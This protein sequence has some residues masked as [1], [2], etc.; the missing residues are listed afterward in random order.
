MSALPPPTPLLE[1][2]S[3]VPS[4]AHPKNSVPRAQSRHGVFIDNIGQEVWR[5]L[6]LSQQDG[7]LGGA[8]E[9]I[10]QVFGH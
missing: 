3:P 2:H 7:A 1:V 9:S 5:P 8:G 4:P 10:T 6:P